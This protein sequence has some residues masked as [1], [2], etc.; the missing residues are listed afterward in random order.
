VLSLLYTVSYLG[1]GLPA[2]IAGFLVVR[3]GGLIDTAYEYG[4]ALIVLAVL[5]LAGLLRTRRAPAA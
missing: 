5:A 4:A 1:M 3:G 2:V